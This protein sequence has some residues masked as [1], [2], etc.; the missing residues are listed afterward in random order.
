MNSRRK[1]KKIFMKY[2][3][4]VIENKDH[5]KGLFSKMFDITLKETIKNTL[6]NEQIKL[7]E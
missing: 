4:E 3:D 7:Y 1:S 2:L 5:T 6:L